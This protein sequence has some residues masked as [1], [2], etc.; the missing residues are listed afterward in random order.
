MYQEEKYLEAIKYFKDI[1]EKFPRE[2]QVKDSSFKIIECLYNL[3]DF[4][5]VKDKVKTYLKLYPKDVT[6]TGYVYFYSAEADYYL[7]N[8]DSAI[9]EFS[10]VLEVSGD[11]KIKG[12]C[13]LGMG[14][15][16]LKLK[17][18]Q[19]AEKMLILKPDELDK[20]NCDTLLLGKAV[21]NFETNNYSTAGKI[22]QELIASAS[23]PQVLIQAYLG[24]ADALYNLA[25]YKEAIK[26]YEE[27]IQKIDSGL[28]VNQEVSDKLHFGLSWSYLK[29]GEFKKAIDEF[30]KLAKQTE[31]KIFK[32]SALCQI[33]D[34]Y[35]D[36]GNFSK[37]VE[38][39]DSI[40][41]DYPDSLY[42]DYVQY[43][44][45]LVLVKLNKYD[46][47]IL[48]FKSLKINYP[49]SK[50]I[51]DAAY[52][53]SLAYFQVEDYTSSKENLKRFENEFKDSSIRPQAMYLLGTSCYNLGQF[54]EA[55]AS[56]KDIVRQ[57]NQD[58]ELVQKAEYEIADCLYQLG[59]EKE[60]MARFK[61]LRTKYPD[62]KLTA[63]VVWWLGEYYYR[64]N[65][66]DLARRYF[67]SLIQDFPQSNLVSS[68]YYAMGS[69]Y[70]EESRFVEAINNFKKVME[71][72]KSDL[73]GTAAV[74][75]SDIYLAQDNFDAALSTLES[76]LKDF[77]HLEHL[78]FPKIADTYAK[79]N[80]LDLAIQFYRKSLKIVPVKEMSNVQFKIAES[81]QAEGKN[82]EAIE[83]YLK[84]SYLYP[85]DLV[86][87]VKSMLRVAALYEDKDKFKEAENIYKK[88][89]GMNV[90][91][92][93]FAQERINWI[94]T[95]TR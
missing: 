80:K 77:P 49:A 95:R 22:Y 72:D 15:S 10:K 16:Y 50:L 1:E 66:L 14:W 81:L 31:D 38:T 70:R 67:N 55:I 93:K 12:L 28:S 65:D 33:G 5:G 39:Y 13:K 91:E 9:S 19:E 56:F 73:A 57:Y 11:T 27:A 36:S 63:E 32:V 68:A 24:K 61:S 7:N 59:N 62:S 76:T 71:R 83:E 74:A 43:Q 94:K 86:L 37:A 46:G 17:K 75:I 54:N 6:N 92:A 64:H 51:D 58:T 2:P 90:D 87:V 42:S 60:A 25:E 82:N 79:L 52:A 18:Y 44:L 40:L 29:E 89:I 88:I 48:A 41:K 78:I 45:G 3:K 85:D 23:D 35:Q 30:Q 4:N 8:F 20:K 53:L 26:A 21:L 69:T 47:A 34:A 84:V